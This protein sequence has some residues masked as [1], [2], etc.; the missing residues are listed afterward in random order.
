[1]PCDVPCLAGHDQQRF[2]LEL[3]V[4]FCSA[5]LLVMLPNTAWSCV[6]CHSHAIHVIMSV[7]VKVLSCLIMSCY[8]FTMVHSVTHHDNSRTWNPEPRRCSQ[9][10][11]PGSWIHLAQNP[12]KDSAC[13]LWSVTMPQLHPTLV[14]YTWPACQ[15]NRFWSDCQSWMSSGYPW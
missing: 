14:M 12:Q 13:G 15:Y 4:W 3:I 10:V 9:H 8:Y 1:M 5:N 11:R 7:C 6:S 2:V